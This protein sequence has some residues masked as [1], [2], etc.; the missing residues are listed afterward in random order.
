MTGSSCVALPPF[1]YTGAQKTG[2]FCA[3]S[4]DNS[5][6][7]TLYKLGAELFLI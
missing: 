5:D 7:T 1:T 2:A 3:L 4:F 6:V